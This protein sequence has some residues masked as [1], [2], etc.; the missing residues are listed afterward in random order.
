MHI[1]LVH[2][3][4]AGDQQP[5]GSLVET[6]RNA[7]H[8]VDDVT[9]DERWQRSLD[10]PADAIV[11]AG[12]DGTARQVAIALAKR[13]ELKLP[14]V[15]VPEG[16]ANNIARSLGMPDDLESIAAGL[17]K[18][19][20]DRLTIGCARAVWG[21]AHFVESAGVGL[22]ATMLQQPR[23][24][25]KRT[26]EKQVAAGADRLRKLLEGA[27]PL[28]VRVL[29]DG[30]DLSGDYLMAQAMNII[31]AGSRVELAPS[32]DPSD[33]SLDLVLI[34]EKER[35]PLLGYLEKL[36]AGEEAES[37]LASR[38][39]RRVVM[40]WPKGAGH[41]DDQA[42]PDDHDV[43]GAEATMEIAT[44]IPILLPGS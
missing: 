21:T 37:P 2:N 17:H 14:L 19:R 16:T 26:K 4:E 42:W 20:S 30:E 3:P 13:P 31:S 27:R 6:F 33:T 28:D 29:A 34:G 39:V 43:V 15:I 25:K 8:Q 11:A 44:T 35:A 18:S 5:T 41:I 22:F 32:A 1:L 12:G 24:A 10:T 23:L 9:I 36:A 38:R 7:G 40:S